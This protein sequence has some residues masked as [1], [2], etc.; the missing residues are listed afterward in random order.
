MTGNRNP[1]AVRT[2]RTLSNL[3]RAGACALVLWAGVVLAEDAQQGVAP[4]RPPPEPGLF[5]AIGRWVDDT[6]SDVNSGF[7]NARGTLDEAA[8]RATDT[9]KGAADAAANVARIPLTSVVSGRKRCLA[10]SNQ[11][12]DCQVATDALCRDKGFKTGRS[13]DV[14]SAQKC[15][16]EVWLSGRSPSAAECTMETYVVRAVCQ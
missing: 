16:A 3:G 10:A 12:P 6:L 9:A 1:F 4:P 14:Q 7:G 11:A 15:P 5:G 13:V 2:G 8:G